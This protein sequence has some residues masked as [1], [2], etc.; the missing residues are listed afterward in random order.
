MPERLSEKAPEFSKTNQRQIF[1]QLLKQ[2]NDSVIVAH[3]N[4]KAERRVPNSGA[5]KQTQQE[6]AECSRS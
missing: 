5:A 1:K 3:E 2:I 4:E 6:A